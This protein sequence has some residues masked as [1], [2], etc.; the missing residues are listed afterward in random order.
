MQKL[1]SKPIYYLTWPIKK[2][3]YIII[4]LIS[5]LIVVLYKL[6]FL[7]KKGWKPAKKFLLKKV[8]AYKRVLAKKKLPRI[9]LPS[10]KLPNITLPS[11]HL[12]KVKIKK[13]F[14]IFLY[15][16]I[17]TLLF[18]L[19]PIK[20]YSWYKSLPDVNLLPVYA[21][22]KTTKIT[23]RNGKLLYEV[24]L[25]KK[26]DPVALQDIPEVV[27]KSTLAI[28]D[29]K[30]YTHHGVRPLSIVRAAKASI[31]D[32]ELQGGSTITQQLIKNVMLT[33]ERTIERK[34]KEVVLAFLVEEKYT[35]DKILELYLN[36]IPYGGTAWGV[37]SASQ[38]YFGKNVKELNLAEASLLAGLPSA[39]SVYSPFSNIEIAKKRQQ[40]VLNRMVKLG[41]ITKADAE[42]AFNQELTFVS[43]EDSI[44]AP[45]F[46]NLVRQ[47]L[48]EMYGDE[49]VTTGGLTVTTTLDLDIQEKVQNIVKEEVAKSGDLNISNGAAVVL[50]VKSGEIL[51]YVG[52]KNY[53]EEGFGEYDILTTQRQPGSSIKPVTYAL[54]FEKGMTPATVIDDSPFVLSNAWETYKPVNYDGKY[55][56]KV[57]LRQALA[58]SYNIPAVKILNTLGPDN[59]VYLG[60]KMGLTNWAVDDSY[61]VSV[62]LGGKEVRPL[63]LANVYA[64]FARGGVYKDTVSFIS[65]KDNTGNELYKRPQLEEQ[66]VSPGVAYL[67]TNILA[68]YYARLPAFGTNNFLSISGHQVAVKTGTTDLKRDNYTFGYTS[69]YV[70][71]VWVGNNDN[72]PMNP[73]LA[74]GLSGAAPIW[75]RVFSVLLS[76]KP[77][78]PFVKPDAITSFYDKDC[79]RSEVFIK[80]SSIPSHLC[81]IEKKED[82]EK[83]EK[84]HND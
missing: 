17:F 7:A 37:Q 76:N 24:F 22:N 49:M 64:T 72:T 9:K 18:V 73:F 28:E 41:Y 19:L 32:D 5:G 16:A 31:I 42:I 57:T 82:K 78:E 45:H 15:G 54:A 56:G 66:V 20:I 79:N 30:F 21:S 25:D 53:F 67:I 75:N 33:S 8:K 36:N 3:G 81:V 60:K 12:P 70:V 1:L 80:G 63:D 83:K 62:T 50:D 39:P 29:D 11:F 55:H 69:S 58:N 44:R 61:G 14:R 26:Y 51:A 43:Q 13:D 84:K 2:I 40:V 4:S 68:D 23:D 59:M 38:K 35:K 27:V 71:G 34:I 47:Q 74:S 6:F 52:S 46:V 10:I 77:D 65:I 48:E